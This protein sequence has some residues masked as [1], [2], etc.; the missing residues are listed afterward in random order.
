[1]EFRAV[2]AM[3]PGCQSR[4]KPFRYLFSLFPAQGHA[5]VAARVKADLE[6]SALQDRTS[7]WPG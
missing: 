4:E 5:A 2:W 6:Q 7:T 3:M 1:M